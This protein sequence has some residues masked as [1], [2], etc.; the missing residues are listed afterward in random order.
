M[1]AVLVFGLLVALCASS[2][3][4]TLH[5]SKPPARHL[6]PFYERQIPR[7]TAAKGFAVP[8]WTD[9]QTRYWLD[10]ASGPKG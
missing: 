7:V 2:E 6:P 1:R 4:A 9:E 5:R 3:A 8:G 10:S